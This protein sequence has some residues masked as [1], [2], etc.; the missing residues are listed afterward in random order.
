MQKGTHMPN[1]REEILKFLGD[2]QSHYANYHNHKEVSAWAGLLL[3]VAL[4]AQFISTAE[5]IIAG[6]FTMTVISIVVVPVAGI[7]LGVFLGVQFYLR[8]KAASYV[9]ACISL[10]SKY[11]SEPDKEIE[12]SK[13]APPSSKHTRS[14]SDRC[15]P[16][17]VLSEA[18]N[19]ESGCFKWRCL[20]EVCVYGV[21]V[22]VSILAVT[23]VWFV[24]A[25]NHV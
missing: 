1:S 2:T 6:S 24:Y 10:R 14:E 3:Y 8:R 7:F 23:R 5:K 11:L 20:L 16:E 15:L 19:M 22:L 17:I 13:F 21:I 9:A 18:G 12:V 4:L 25:C